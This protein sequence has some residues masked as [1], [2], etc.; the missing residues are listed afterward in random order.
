M[1]KPVELLMQKEMSRKEFL[2]TLALGIGS[3][4]GLSTIIHLL[5]G[6]SLNKQ[7]SKHFGIGYGFGAYGGKKRITV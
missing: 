7:A 4:M 6:K 1:A 2:G 5:T 3:I